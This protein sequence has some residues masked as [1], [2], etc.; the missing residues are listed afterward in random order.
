MVQSTYYFAYLTLK[1]ITKFCACSRLT[2]A[3][4]HAFETQLSYIVMKVIDYVEYMIEF[5]IQNAT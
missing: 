4:M 3:T 2:I 5:F 1:N